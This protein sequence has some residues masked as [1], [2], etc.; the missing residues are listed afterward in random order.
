MQAGNTF[1]DLILG[2]NGVLDQESKESC[3]G[4][5]VRQSIGVVRLFG[6]IH[7]HGRL[8]STLD[9]FVMEMTAIQLFYT[10]RRFVEFSTHQILLEKLVHGLFQFLNGSA[11]TGAPDSFQTS[12]T[13]FPTQQGD[14]LFNHFV[15]GTIVVLVGQK[16]GRQ[17]FVHHGSSQKG[18]HHGLL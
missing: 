6:T 1:L 2:N 5:N 14:G 16:G 12:R 9:Q 3:H 4:I 17:D 11:V 10:T 8:G 18:S 13:M 15:A 7:L